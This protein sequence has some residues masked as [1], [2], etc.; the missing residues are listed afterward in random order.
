M[1]KI[2]KLVSLGSASV[3]SEPASM[4]RLRDVFSPLS[5]LLREKNGFYAFEG[6][7]HVF[8]DVGSN[9]E[10]GVV[11]WNDANLWRDAYIDLAKFGIF[12]AEDIFGNQFCW[13]DGGVSA[14]DAE[15]GS[16]E[17]V[18]SGIEEWADRILT[19]YNLWT[20]FKLAHEW[21]EKN[22][23]LPIGRRLLPKQPFVLGGEYEVKN[24]YAADAVTGMRYRGTIATQIRDVPDGSTVKLRIVE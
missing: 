1:T 17:R 10:P 2:E 19:E 14:F 23:T 4:E 22:G 11:R 24:L 12:F 9:L 20:G 18:A 6:A 21:Q 8:S 15:T 5:L 13:R 3:V 16:Y 7:L